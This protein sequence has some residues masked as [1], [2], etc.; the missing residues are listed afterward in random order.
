MDLAIGMETL[1]MMALI[2]LLVAVVVAVRVA[3]ELMVLQTPVEVVGA[4]VRAL[5]LCRWAVTERMEFA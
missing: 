4:A 5:L 2:P 1:D 3:K